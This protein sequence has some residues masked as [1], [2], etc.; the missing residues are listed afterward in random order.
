MEQD[1]DEAS[2]SRPD[3]KLVLI[4]DDD[5][6]QMELLDHIVRKEGFRVEH[7]INGT[8]AI[9]KIE[10]LSPHAVLLDL[11][12]PGMGGYELVRELQAKGLGDAPVI[13]ITAREMDPK[14]IEMIRAEPN[15]RDVFKKP[16][17]PTILSVALHS[18]LK[19]RPLGRE[20]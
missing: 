2:L 13:I 6:S 16:P 15:V 10:A 7:A 1:S 12:L 20:P 3:E 9:S 8:D 5:E 14:T 19:T 11:M 17:S 18:L 4:V